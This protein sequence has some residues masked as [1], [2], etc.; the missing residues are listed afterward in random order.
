MAAAYGR[1]RICQILRI[2]CT[3]GGAC[4]FHCKRSE[5]GR[6]VCGD[7]HSGVKLGESVGKPGLRRNRMQS[8]RA[9]ASANR[10]YI[11]TLP[12]FSSPSLDPRPAPALS[13]AIRSILPRPLQLSPRGSSSQRPKPGKSLRHRGCM[14]GVAVLALARL[15][16]RPHPIAKHTASIGH[17]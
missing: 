17:A 11:S 8:V 15:A 12:Y 9:C 5:G 1:A 3:S 4:G 13:C 6:E 16:T 10:P 2:D 14:H 7:E